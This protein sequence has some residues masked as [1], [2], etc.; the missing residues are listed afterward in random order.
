[1]TLR[2]E[3]NDSSEP[4]ISDETALY[5]IR[6]SVA[7]R[8]VLIRGQLHDAKGRH[9]AMGAFWTD[10]P[11]LAAHKALIEEVTA[12]NDSLPKNATPKERWKKVNS[13]LRWKLQVLAANK[14]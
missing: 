1:M 3:C 11:E 10:N 4:A 9:C 5:L 13:W 6:D 12:V 8:R 7:K 2:P 14:T